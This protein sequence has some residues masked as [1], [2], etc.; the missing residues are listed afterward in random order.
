M[1]YAKTHVISHRCDEPMR[2]SKEKCWTKDNKRWKCTGD[3]KNCVCCIA[4][5]ANGDE[6]HLGANKWKPKHIWTVTD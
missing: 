6:A 4:K 5:D 1:H 2:R 3:C